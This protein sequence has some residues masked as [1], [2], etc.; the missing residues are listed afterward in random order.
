M[1]GGVVDNHILSLGYEQWDVPLVYRWGPLCSRVAWGAGMWGVTWH[2]HA[3]W[4]GPLLYTWVLQ[5]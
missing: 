3:Q 2:W 5:C 4:G 1:T